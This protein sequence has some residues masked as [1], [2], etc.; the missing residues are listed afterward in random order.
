MAY[1]TKLLSDGEKV[2]R[3]FRPHWQAIA[4]PVGIVI[5]TTLVGGVLGAILDNVGVPLAIGVVLGLVIAIP[6]LMVWAF[7]KYVI[8][9]ER[10]IVRS[11]VFARHGKEIP[12]EVIN[13][14]AFSQ[15]LLER[16]F[17]SGD[18]L[19]ES[20]GEMGQSRF[21]NI[22]TPEEIQTLIYKARESRMS[23]LNSGQIA[24]D[25]LTTLAQLHRDGVLTDEEFEAK[26]HKLLGEI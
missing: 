11:G 3:E 17:G 12:L 21:T 23:A 14:V 25:T 24:V 2:V 4:L 6:K 20:A 1:P 10:V 7:T 16:M 13:D 22:P 8:T 15:S 5:G 19:L 26:K 18:L 9:N